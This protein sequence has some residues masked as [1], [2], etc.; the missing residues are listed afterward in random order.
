MLCY[1]LCHINLATVVNTCLL[2][3][4]ICILL[5]LWLSSAGINDY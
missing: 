1:I 2:L 4:H 5:P 3:E